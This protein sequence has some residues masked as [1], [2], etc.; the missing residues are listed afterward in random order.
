MIDIGIVVNTISTMFALIAGV[1]WVRLSRR[2]IRIFLAGLAAL[3]TTC[4]MIWGVDSELALIDVLL[5]HGLQMASGMGMLMV[6]SALADRCRFLSQENLV[7]EER[8]TELTRFLA[9]ASHDLRQ[10]MHALNIYLGSLTNVELP[11]A[12][13]PLLSKVCL[14]AN[15]MD[16]MFL[17]L[18]DLSRL[19]A[20][21]VQPRIVAFPITS[22]LARLEVEFSPQA[23]AKGLDLA[24]EP[25]A[26]WAESDPVLVEQILSNLL[27]NAVRYTDTGR[28]DVGCSSGNG[29]VQIAVRDTGVGISPQQ[30][31]TVFEEFFQVTNVN[32]SRDKGLG[33]GLAI[34]RRLCKLLGASIALASKPGEGSTFTLD[35][36]L[37]ELPIET[38]TQTGGV[39]ARDQNFLSDKLILVVENEGSI[40]DAMRTLLEQRGCT[41]IAAASTIEATTKISATNRIPDALIC[42]YGL[43]PHETGLDV[44]NNLHKKFGDD[45]S[46][47]LVTG[48]TEQ[49]IIQELLSSGFIVMHKPMRAEMLLDV[50]AYMLN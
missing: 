32:G 17:A 44:I 8:Q 22:V 41:V 4:L 1:M 19:N 9:V 30:Q 36:P 45:I 37:K 46:A 28:I 48:N 40:R 42:D 21:V 18:L 39:V 26:A 14:C 49:E 15:I 31:N 27:A 47:M 3:A 12:A 29:R 25:T 35:L 38:V 20:Q 34:V 7:R 16:E 10:P 23:H 6:A 24:I 13:K 2:N 33:L 43:N 11:E 50:L 5:I